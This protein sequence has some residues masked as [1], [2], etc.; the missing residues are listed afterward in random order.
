MDDEIEG[1]W[2]ENSEEDVMEVEEVPETKKKGKNVKEK[3]PYKHTPEITTVD[4]SDD[5]LEVVQELTKE[6]KERMKKVETLGLYK[7]W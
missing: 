5:E 3:R 6:E 2:S 7:L 1:N 4:V